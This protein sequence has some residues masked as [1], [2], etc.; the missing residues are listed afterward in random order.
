MFLE[1][2]AQRPNQGLFKFVQSLRTR[3][4]SGGGA[5]LLQTPGK[6]QQAFALLYQTT[7]QAALQPHAEA[8]EGVAPLVGVGHGKLS[9]RRGRG[10]AHVGTAQREALRRLSAAS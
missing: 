4:Q 5:R 8:C 2:A 9:R 3:V 10:R 1:P 7:A 6:P